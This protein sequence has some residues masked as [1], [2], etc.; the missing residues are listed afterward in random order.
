MIKQY[1]KLIHIFLYIVFST[2]SICKAA[3][4]ASVKQITLIS[5]DKAVRPSNVMGASNRLSELILQAYSEK[6]K[7]LKIWLFVR[8]LKSP[9]SVEYIANILIIPKTKIATTKI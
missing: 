8:Y 1:S 6:T 5:T 3:E 7:N 2:L 9:P 4:K